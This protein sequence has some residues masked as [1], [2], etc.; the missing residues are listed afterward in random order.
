MGGKPQEV[1]PIKA[2]KDIKKVKQYLSEDGNKRDFTLFTVG[3]NVGL[4]ASDLL[5][6]KVGDVR[7]VDGT[8]KDSVSLLEQKTGKVRTFELNKS[9]KEAL[10]TYLQG[11]KTFTDDQYLF[12]S[13]KGVNSPLEVR[14]LHKIMKSTMRELGIKGNYGTHTLRKTFGYHVYSTNIVDNPM[15]LPTLQKMFNHSSQEITLRYIGITK[16]VIRNVYNELNL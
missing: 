14:S 4:R 6:L 16:E 5:S 9:A 15:I 13:R 7:N 2:V 11:L 1:E 10:G 8:I 3:I 12:Q